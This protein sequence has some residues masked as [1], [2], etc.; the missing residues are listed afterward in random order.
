MTQRRF[1]LRD[2]AWG[3]V[4]VGFLIGSALLP[5]DQPCVGCD[6]GRRPGAAARARR[7]AWSGR[8]L[9][10]GRCRSSRDVPHSRAR[11]T[12]GGAAES[13]RHPGHRRPRRR[14]AAVDEERRRR[15]GTDVRPA[16]RRRL[17]LRVRR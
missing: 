6:G 7:S 1:L 15:L 12:E 17:P 10:G 3:G 11:R 4:L 14:A 16:A 9:A 2:L 13:R 8:R 5:A